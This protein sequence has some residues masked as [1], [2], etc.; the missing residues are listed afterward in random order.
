MPEAIVLRAYGGP[1]TLIPESVEVGTPE[2]GEIR[3]R[4]TA[5]GVNYHDVYV[6]TG[7]YQTLPLYSRGRSPDSRNS[8]D[9]LIPPTLR[10]HFFPVL[11]RSGSL[12]SAELR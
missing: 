8:A 7:L 4:Q 11:R 5:I 10:G 2:P 6:R 12:V 1:E 3:I 9:V